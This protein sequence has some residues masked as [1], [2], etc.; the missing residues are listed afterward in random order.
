MNSTTVAMDVA[1]LA[2]PYALSNFQ[3]S[4]ASSNRDYIQ[5]R[6]DHLRMESLSL[7]LSCVLPLVKG[8]NHETG[9]TTLHTVYE[10]KDETLRLSYGND[11]GFLSDRVAS[12]LPAKSLV[13]LI[14]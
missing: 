5:L 7:A 14:P 9:D 4:M 3:P 12:R 2:L 10:I 8:R 11:R 1:G 13:V 6:Q